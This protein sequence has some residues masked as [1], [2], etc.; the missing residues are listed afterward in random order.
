MSFCSLTKGFTPKISK[1]CLCHNK[2]AFFKIFYVSAIGQMYQLLFC[3]TGSQKK[4]LKKRR[5]RKRMCVCVLDREGSRVFA[6][7]APVVA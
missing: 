4:K 1:L 5:R 2:S 3:L 7:G 6:S